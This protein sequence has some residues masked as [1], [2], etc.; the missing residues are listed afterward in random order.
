M[1]LLRVFEEDVFAAL[2]GVVLS[3]HGLD[4]R[5]AAGVAGFAWFA[6][7]FAGHPLLGGGGLGDRPSSRRGWRPLTMFEPS[8]R[9]MGINATVLGGGGDPVVG[10]VARVGQHDRGC[11]PEVPGDLVDHRAELVAVC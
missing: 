9:G 5:F 11:D 1:M 3:E 8:G 4:D 6:S 10:E 7:E 2:D